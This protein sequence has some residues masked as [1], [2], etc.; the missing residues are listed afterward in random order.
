MKDGFLG[1]GQTCPGVEQSGWCLYK[2]AAS[3]FFA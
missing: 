3:L 1:Y 2:P